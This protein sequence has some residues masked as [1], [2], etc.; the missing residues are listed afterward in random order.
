MPPESPPVPYEPA[1]PRARLVALLDRLR[2][3]DGTEAA[4]RRYAREW[5]AGGAPLYRVRKPD[6][7]AVHLV[8][9]FTVVDPRTGRLLLTDHRGAG[10]RLP[11]GG[12]VEP[13]DRDPWATVARECREELFVEAAP[14]EPTGRTPFFV[15]VART[16]G[17]GSHTDV[18]LWYAVQARPEEI[19]RYDTREFAGIGWVT[20]G[21]ARA[22]PPA[23]TDP[24][25][26]RAVRGLTTLLGA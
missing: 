24:N 11:P 9:Y 17:A 21:E 7:P 25:L 26:G 4:H 14:L 10:L 5:A 3:A 12:H 19:T 23:T 6:V 15:S 20:P 1:D 16:R 8:A 18:S 22:L 2:P 13:A